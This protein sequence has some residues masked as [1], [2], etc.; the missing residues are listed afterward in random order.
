[1]IAAIARI[2]EPRS[3]RIEELRQRQS[4]MYCQLLALQSRAHNARAQ[5]ATARGQAERAER[6]ALDLA[7]RLDEVNAALARM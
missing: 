5:E 6:E 2:P 4:A 7:A 1:M 3:A